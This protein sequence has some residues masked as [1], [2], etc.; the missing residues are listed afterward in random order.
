VDVFFSD[1]RIMERKI[2]KEVYLAEDEEILIVKKKK[3]SSFV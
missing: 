2:K 3:P 1:K